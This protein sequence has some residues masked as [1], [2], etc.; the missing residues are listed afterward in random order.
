MPV[1]LANE[2]GYNSSQVG[3]V[4]LAQLIPSFFSIPLC[5][6]VYDRFGPK[7]LSSALLILT[8]ICAACMG[9]PNSTSPGGVAPLIV[10]FAL[11]GFWGA[12]LTVIALP[13]C[14]H[15]VKTL[16]KGGDDG[17]AQSYAMVNIA[18]AIG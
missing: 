9:L 8:A 7:L 16:T 4:F 17:I 14:A 12:A 2:W 5:G 3:I 11:E 10:L 1:H 6:Y 18:F 13:E 15:S